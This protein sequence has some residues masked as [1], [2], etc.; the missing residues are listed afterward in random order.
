MQTDT[1]L[2]ID[3]NT[4]QTIND[5]PFTSLLFKLEETY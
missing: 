1:W 2:E 3:F 5:L 4:E